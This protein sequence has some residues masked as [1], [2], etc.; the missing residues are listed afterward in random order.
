MALQGVRFKSSSNHI[1]QIARYRTM[2]QAVL[3]RRCQAVQWTMRLTRGAQEGQQK[4]RNFLGLPEK[5]PASQ[6]AAEWK[7]KGN[8]PDDHHR[9]QRCTSHRNPMTNS[10]P[11]TLF[12]MTDV[13]NKE[14]RPIR[15]LPSVRYTRY[16]SNVCFAPTTWSTP[17][18][19]TAGVTGG[20]EEA[21]TG[22]AGRRRAA[23]ALPVRSSRAIFCS[24]FRSHVFVNG[25]RILPKT[26]PLGPPPPSPAL[27]V[28]TSA[29]FGCMFK[30]QRTS[31]PR[32]QRHKSQHLHHVSW[33]THNRSNEA[34]YSSIG[35]A[36]HCTLDRPLPSL[37]QHRMLCRLRRGLLRWL[38]HGQCMQ[39]SYG[40]PQQRRQ[41]MQHRL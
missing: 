20:R 10:S 18:P 36:R 12:P 24:C 8:Q 27:Q 23:A 3:C 22:T 13:P 32:H 37:F 39:C 14:G 34:A 2:S 26:L 16:S 7:V 35:L 17:A 5:S 4:H 30:V 33:Q 28:Y 31:K 9:R 11:C 19:P 29:L 25:E 21:A 1:S 40:L 6:W 38:R 15:A 41:C